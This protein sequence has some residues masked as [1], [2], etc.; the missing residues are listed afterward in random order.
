MKNF[1]TIGLC[2]AASLSFAANAG[3]V[4]GERTYSVVDMHPTFYSA[5]KNKHNNYNID[6]D[7]HHNESTFAWVIYPDEFFKTKFKHKFKPNFSN[8]VHLFINSDIPMQT[9]QLETNKNQ[10]SRRSPTVKPLHDRSSDVPEPAS[11]ALLMIGLIGVAIARH[12]Q[13]TFPTEKDVQ[14]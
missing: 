7:A 13:G 6:F 5:I 9:D 3:V 1:N 10:I 8:L 2:L 12:R 4:F 11:M 14:P